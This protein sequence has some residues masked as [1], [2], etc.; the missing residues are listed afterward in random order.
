MNEGITWAGQLEAFELLHTRTPFCKR[1]SGET[2]KET[3]ST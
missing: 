3:T 2:L 1:E